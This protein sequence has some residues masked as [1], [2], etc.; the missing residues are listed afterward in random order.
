MVGECKVQVGLMS[1]PCTDGRVS[2]AMAGGG[3]EGAIYHDGREGGERRLKW[4]GCWH[5]CSARVVGMRW[6]GTWHV[7]LAKT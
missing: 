7:H 5:D 3:D 6:W 2:W 4:G 1:T